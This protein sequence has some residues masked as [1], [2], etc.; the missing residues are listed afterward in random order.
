MVYCRD[1]HVMALNWLCTHAPLLPLWFTLP[2]HRAAES[3]CGGK[4]AQ[5]KKNGKGG[6]RSSELLEEFAIQLWSAP[7]A[8][9]AAS[10]TNRPSAT[11]LISPQELL[12]KQEVRQC[13]DSDCVSPSYTPPIPY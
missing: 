8:L 4:V 13:A 3:K 7:A 1:S 11:K 10:L 5:M 2:Q 9:K 12:G 6:V